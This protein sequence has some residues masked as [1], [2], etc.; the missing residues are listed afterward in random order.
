M[1]T[2]QLVIGIITTKTYWTLSR[3]QEMGGVMGGVNH[4]AY[5]VLTG[6][7]GCCLGLLG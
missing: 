5:I 3:L 7:S 1:A 4:E 6:S 2:V